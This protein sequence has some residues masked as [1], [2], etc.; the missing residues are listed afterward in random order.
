[1]SFKIS[2]YDSLMFLNM[3]FDP[4]EETCFAKHVKETSLRNMMEGYYSD[5]LFFSIN[6]MIY[7]RKDSNVH[8]YRNIL[9][10]LDIGSRE[11][12]DDIIHRSGLPYTTLV[13]SGNKSYHAIV[14]L[15]TPAKNAEEY[16]AIVK[17]IYDKMGG[18]SVVDIK[19]GNPSR[20]SRLPEVWRI[21]TGTKQEICKVNERVTRDRLNAWLGESKISPVQKRSKV[22]YK[23]EDRR[24]SLRVQSFLENGAVEGSRNQQLFVNACEMFRAGYDSDEIFDM[25]SEALDLPDYEKRRTI[26]SADRATNEE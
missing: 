17:S 7:T 11:E 24:L 23:N 5:E 10:E 8:T 25:V 16:A 9:V 1:M 15:E 13:W 12:Q 19:T 4:P 21:D 20:L 18:P 6:P 3:L 26:A 22:E 2:T 14:S